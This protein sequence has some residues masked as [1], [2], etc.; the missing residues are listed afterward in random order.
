MAIA[1]ATC[2]KRGDRTRQEEGKK[3]GDGCIQMLPIWMMFRDFFVFWAWA[4]FVKL[5][6]DCE[7]GPSREGCERRA[8]ETSQLR[9]S[10]TAEIVHHR[11]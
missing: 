11:W 1:A 7:M 3:E 6:L 5:Q 2:R 4:C 9:P 10:M 8:R